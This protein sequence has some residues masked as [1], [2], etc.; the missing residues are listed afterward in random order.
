MYWPEHGGNMLMFGISSKKPQAGIKGFTWFVKRMS[1]AHMPLYCNCFVTESKLNSGAYRF[2]PQCV[3]YLDK[4]WGKCVG[5]KDTENEQ[6]VC[7]DEW[8][9]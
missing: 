7:H 1:C 3:C 2:P 4:G 9:K 8:M 6:E 5:L